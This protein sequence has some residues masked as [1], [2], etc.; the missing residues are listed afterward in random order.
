MDDGKTESNA[1]QCS[2]KNYKD[3]FLY[4][5]GKIKWLLNI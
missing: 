1:M 2:N 4:V 5:T 3:A